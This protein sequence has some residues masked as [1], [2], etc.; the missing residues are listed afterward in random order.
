MESSEKA[1]RELNYDIDVDSIE[2]L[3]EMLRESQQKMILFSN[4]HAATSTASTCG[5]S[6]AM[7]VYLE[8]SQGENYMYYYFLIY[9]YEMTKQDLNSLL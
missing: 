1:V 5:Q 2:E 9:V 3:Y 6:I 4:N 7:N 8:G